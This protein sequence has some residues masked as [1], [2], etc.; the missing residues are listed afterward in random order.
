[1]C[2]DRSGGHAPPAAR[3]LF[4]LAGVLLDGRSVAW[5]KPILRERVLLAS[6]RSNPK[7][8]IVRSR[9]ARAVEGLASLL[10]FGGVIS[11]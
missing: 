11:V 6:A 1:M 4:P 5:G 7:I 10:V 3:H 2:F 9:A 8:G